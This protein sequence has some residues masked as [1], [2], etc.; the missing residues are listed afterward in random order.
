MDSV[1]WSAVGSRSTEP[2]SV[3]TALRYHDPQEMMIERGLIYC[4][5]V[6]ACRN[7]FPNA[8]ITMG[9]CRSEAGRAPKGRP[10]GEVL[11]QP[12]LRMDDGLMERSSLKGVLNGPS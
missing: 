5:N 1:A 7:R 8:I 4:K 12:T 11:A 10:R 3:E 6:D 9:L 2:G